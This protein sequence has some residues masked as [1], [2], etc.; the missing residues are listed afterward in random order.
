MKRKKRGKGRLKKLAG[1]YWRKQ[2]K[3]KRQE[4]KGAS[5]P[6]TAEL[7]LPAELNELFVQ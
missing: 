3:W 7:G 4:N 2:I 1:G 6:V 5:V